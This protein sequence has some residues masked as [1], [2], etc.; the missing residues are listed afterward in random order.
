MD[1]TNNIGPAPHHPAKIPNHEEPA[2]PKEPAKPPTKQPTHY[3]PMI[4]DPCKGKPTIASLFG[5]PSKKE[6]TPHAGISC[7][8]LRS[9]I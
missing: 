9:I 2:K 1:N 5:G 7:R 6:N 8:D 3:G 4:H